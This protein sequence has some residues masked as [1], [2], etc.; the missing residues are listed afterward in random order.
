MKKYTLMS[1]ALFV[2]L[3]AFGHDIHENVSRFQNMPVQNLPKISENKLVPEMY[4]GIGSLILALSFAA[5]FFLFKLKSFSTL[6]YNSMLKLTALVISC[7]FSFAFISIQLKIK[8]VNNDPAQ[9]QLVFAPFIPEVNTF[10]DNTYFY[11]ES[12]GIP[13]THE[14]MVGISNDGW[15]QQVPIP[16]CYIGNNAWPIPLNPS[17][18]ANPVAID[19]VHFTRGAIA[20]AVNG[21]PIFNV[22]TNTGVDSYLDGQ[23]DAFGGHCG[24][25]DDYHYHTAPLHL[26]DYVPISQPIAYGLDGF[27]V[28]G[29]VE[30]DGSPMLSL[31][32]NHGHFGAD[33]NY[34]YHGTTDAPYMIARFAGEVTEDNTNQLI[35]QAS[36]TPIRPPLTP[37]AGALITNCTP[38]SDNQGYSLQYTLNNTT[39]SVVY[40]W[41]SQGNYAF[42][43][44]T[45]GSQTNESYQGFI[46]CEVPIATEELQL[47]FKSYISLYPNPCKD[48][49]NVLIAANNKIRK[50][51]ILNSDGKIVYSQIGFINPINT[52]SL[53]PGLHFL[54]LTSNGKTEVLRFVIIN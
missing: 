6:K 44:F 46:P 21:V 50:T 8:S 49:L 9:M 41:N 39:D 33:G 32:A 18:S 34:H 5:Y 24:R 37:L 36:S 48:K 17:M 15:Q 23:L 53:S 45:N 30:P 27:P 42:Q 7:G 47:Q 51:E 13:K 4:D 12:K 52:S 26:Y 16:Q 54:K 29:L 10:S 28:Y 43:F 2:C 40:N 20:I 31:D 22:Y 11:V 1:F 3:F 35:P 19:N 38:H 25:A 14:M